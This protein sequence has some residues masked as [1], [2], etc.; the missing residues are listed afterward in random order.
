MSLDI[1]THI[2]RLVGRLVSEYRINWIYA[3]RRL[4]DSDHNG[5]SVEP[6]SAEHRAML[7]DSATYKMRNSQSYA[8]AGLAGL[9]LVKEGRPVSVAHFVEAGQYRRSSTWPLRDGEVALMD[10][11]TEEQVR[12]CGLAPQLIRAA[13]RI[14]LARGCRGMIAFIWWSNDASRHAFE[15][16]GWRRIGGSVELRFGKRWLR[17]RVPLRWEH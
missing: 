9:V 6:E 14:Y 16:A 5:L 7:S 1:K 15:K 8:K 13:T 10:I 2:K 4:P 3:A 17:I 11:A 12:G